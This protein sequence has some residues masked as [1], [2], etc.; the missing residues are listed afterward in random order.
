MEREIWSV[1]LRISRSRLTLRPGD[2][3]YVNVAGKPVVV[4]SSQ[5]IAGDL[6]DRRATIYS[7]RPQ[8]IV[9]N[10]LMTGG[11]LITFTHY[12][13]VLVSLLLLSIFH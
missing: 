1:S 6:M 13:D 7:D 10:D 5:K 4:I 12:N 3:I 2:L 11:L 8:N 9:P